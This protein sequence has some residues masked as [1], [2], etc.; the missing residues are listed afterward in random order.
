MSQLVVSQLALS[1][2]AVSQLGAGALR[3]RQGLWGVVVSWGH[4]Y[5]GPPWV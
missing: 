1:Q 4:H 3:V 2:P 5:Q